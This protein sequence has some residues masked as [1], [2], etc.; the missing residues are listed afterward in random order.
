MLPDPFVARLAL[1]KAL[2]PK[3]RPSHSCPQC[4]EPWPYATVCD[5]CRDTVR[6]DDAR[7]E[8]WVQTEVDALRANGG[9]W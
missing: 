7:T 1:A 9:G 2:Q 8:S 3:R 5:G 6:D 4:G